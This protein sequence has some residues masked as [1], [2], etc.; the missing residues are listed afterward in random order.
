MEGIAIQMRFNI[1][2]IFLNLVRRQTLY[3]NRII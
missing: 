2:I 3:R 1:A